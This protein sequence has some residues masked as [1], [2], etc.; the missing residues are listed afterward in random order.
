MFAT[1]V[2]GIQI[3]ISVAK[4][5]TLFVFRK[6][7]LIPESTGRSVTNRTYVHNEKAFQYSTRDDEDSASTCTNILSIWA[8]F[9]LILLGFVPEF[10]KTLT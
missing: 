3:V 6:D 4:A 7:P 1:T 8:R 5:L 9:R 2:R 10:I